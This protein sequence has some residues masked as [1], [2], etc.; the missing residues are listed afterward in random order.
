MATACEVI[1]AT[2]ASVDYVQDH[3]ASREVAQGVSVRLA[4]RHNIWEGLAGEIPS[5]V[6]SRL[7]SS[8]SGISEVTR[9]QLASSLLGFSHGE[10]EGFAEH[11][12]ELFRPGDDRCNR[13]VLD[14]FG[15]LKRPEERQE[16]AHRLLGM[17]RSSGRGR[18]S[19]DCQ[20]TQFVK[21]LEQLSG[22][23]YLDPF[24]PEIV[25]AAVALSLFLLMDAK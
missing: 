10:R 7:G 22:R 25:Q 16:F 20:Q 21:Q 15:S 8:S 5:T 12:F 18:A 23:F 19:D 11:A 9:V 4:I 24:S 1:A 2:A 6:R 14:G 17:R 3:N 13:A